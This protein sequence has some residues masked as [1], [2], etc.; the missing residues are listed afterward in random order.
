MTI[1]NLDHP[2]RGTI[3]HIAI[4]NPSV[5]AVKRLGSS[6]RLPQMFLVI[7]SYSALTPLL[8][9]QQPEIRY[10]RD[11]RPILSDKC[12]FCH[13]PDPKTREEDLR[14][15]IRED[16]IASKAFIPGNPE[17]SRLIKLINA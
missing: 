5:R 4:I 2:I 10:G 14:L 6:F 12:F 3:K 11:I 8:L 9:G 13:G 15:D 7:L 1:P 17:K 16:A